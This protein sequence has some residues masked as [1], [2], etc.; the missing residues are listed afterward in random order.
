MRLQI[1]D[2]FGEE[3]FKSLEILVVWVMSH[4]PSFEALSGW[5]TTLIF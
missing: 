1:W 3:K 5:I 4:P 2:T